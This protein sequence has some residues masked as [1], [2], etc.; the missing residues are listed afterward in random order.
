[1]F[2]KINTNN[3]IIS[4][5]LDFS[6]S[7]LK[8][9]WKFFIILIILAL[10]SFS[11]S[12]LFLWWNW[13]IAFIFYILWLLTN[14]IIKVISF[15]PISFNFNI[16]LNWNN[17]FLYNIFIILVILIKL[18]FILT[19]IKFIQ[20]YFTK[21]IIEEEIIENKNV[22]KNEIKN[23]NTI[24]YNIIL[25]LK[26]KRNHLTLFWIIKEFILKYYFPFLFTIIWFFVFF[27][28]YSN[29]KINVIY[30]YNY[31]N[32]IKQIKLSWK[33][34]ID[35][36]NKIENN[37]DIVLQNNN[38]KKLLTDSSLTK[39]NSIFLYYNTKD[40]KYLE[41]QNF[42]KKEIWI[43]KNIKKYPLIIKNLFSIYKLSLEKNTNSIIYSPLFLSKYFITLAY[44]NW[45]N[46]NNNYY[47]TNK[48]IFI[49]S[50]I[51]IL[52]IISW[53]DINLILLLKWLVYKE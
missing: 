8:N 2:K 22:I 34:N 28:V 13:V 49:Y 46:L 33:N 5:L 18:L 26:W 25:F 37:K 43:I 1:M 12:F 15:V 32:N 31:N 53:L 35:I 20:L 6:N 16:W 24:L 9:R 41:T 29:K 40:N 11:L 21:H 39:F 14:I 36:L 48:L 38:Y 52:F 17:L 7:Y 50:I 44:F 19:F 42:T 51:F 45:K 10:L 3:A 27:F 4:F 47:K 23:W 30:K